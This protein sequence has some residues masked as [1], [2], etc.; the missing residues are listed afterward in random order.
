VDDCDAV[1]QR[2]VEAGCEVRMPLQDMFWGDR[3]GLLAD[4]YGHVWSVATTVRQVGL[5]E[6]QQA[7]N[8]MSGEACPAN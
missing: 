5:E 4:P 8:S 2:A 6:L 7:M 3:Y 1:F